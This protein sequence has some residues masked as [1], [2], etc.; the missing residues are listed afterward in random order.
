VAAMKTAC[1]RRREAAAVGTHTLIVIALSAALAVPTSWGPPA[2]LL[3]VRRAA[4]VCRT[5][6]V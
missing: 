3:D 4:I 1:G 6:E 2:V 5:E